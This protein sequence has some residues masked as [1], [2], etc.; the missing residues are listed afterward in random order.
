MPAA[1]SFDALIIGAG[2]AGTP[3]A[4]ALAAAGKTVGFIE[5]DHLGGSCINYGCAPTKALLASAQRA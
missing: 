4:Y 2:Q 1:N 3:L 5:S